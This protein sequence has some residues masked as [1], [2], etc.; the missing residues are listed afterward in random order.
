[1]SEGCLPVCL[2]LTLGITKRPE[3]EDLSGRDGRYGESKSDKKR[4][5]KGPFKAL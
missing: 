5:A 1:M 4:G 2:G 3:A